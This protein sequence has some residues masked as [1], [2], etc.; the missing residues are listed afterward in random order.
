M[1]EFGLMHHYSPLD[2]SKTIRYKVWQRLFHFKTENRVAAHIV[3][4]INK[5][6]LDMPNERS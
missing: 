5:T 6:F 2:V 1:R 4:S 3:L